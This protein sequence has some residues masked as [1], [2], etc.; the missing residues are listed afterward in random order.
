MK[1][2]GVNQSI[3]RNKCS[4]KAEGKARKLCSENHFSQGVLVNNS[5]PLYTVY[6]K[7]TNKKRNGGLWEPGFS[8]LEQEF[9]H[10]QGEKAPMIRVVTG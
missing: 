6:W 1:R 10:K 8:L 5:K 3:L 2:E 7:R 4:C 9:I